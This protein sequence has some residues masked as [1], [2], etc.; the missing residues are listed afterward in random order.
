M[1][2][3]FKFDETSIKV[4]KVYAGHSARINT[5]KWIRNGSTKE[6]EIVSGSDD[7]LCIYWDII[8]IDAP[9]KYLLKGHTSGVTNIDTIYVNNILTVVTGSADSSIKLWRKSIINAEFT[10]FQ[11]ISLNTGICFA[12][13]MVLLPESND[14]LLAFAT[15]DDKI[16]LFAEEGDQYHRVECLSG[17]EDWVRALDFI[18]DKNGDLL[19]ASCSQD[20]FI[21][22]WKISSRSSEPTPRTASTLLQID[23][24]NFKVNDKNYALALESVVRG[25]ENWVYGIQWHR[26]D[27][28]NLQFLSSSMDKTMI[29]WTIDESDIWSE[30]VRVGGVGGNSLGFYGGK[31]RP[32]GKSIIGHGYQGSFHLWHQS[33]ENKDL[34]LPGVVCSGHYKEVKDVAWEPSG[35]FLFSVSTDQTSRIHSS[36]CREGH[37]VT[38]YHEI[39]R[40]QVHGYD[41][42][43][44]AVLSRFRFASGADEKIVRTFQAPS[45][46]VENLKSLAKVDL[47]ESGEQILQSMYII[48]VSTYTLV[49][50]KLTL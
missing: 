7:G 34:W 27:S 47:D 31:F 24:R 22:L 16:H 10:C 17:H 1:L 2:N 19:L 48:L 41:M 21:R 18:L 49:Y 5:V 6:T 23:E 26:D 14:I 9:V 32:N 42:T 29:I 28:G 44:I 43:C 3:L 15:D 37:E 25:H 50:T 35:E 46:F 39:A 40:P 8:D 33:E 13:R 38:T 11:T 45:N 20:T 30:K 4:T 12:V 36:W